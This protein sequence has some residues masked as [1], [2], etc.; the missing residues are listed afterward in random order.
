MQDM[1]V[2]PGRLQ[3]VFDFI[4]NHKQEYSEERGQLDEESRCTLEVAEAELK[5]E[6]GKE[7]GP[8]AVC[9]TMQTHFQMR[10]MVLEA[11]RA[12]LDFPAEHHV[13]I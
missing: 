11:L 2:D 8:A 5:Y 9:Q 4:S 13:Y 10:D 1:L 12:D 7:Q 3:E 6:W